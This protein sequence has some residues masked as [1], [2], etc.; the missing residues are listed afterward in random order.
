MYQNKKQ[1]EIFVGY[2]TLWEKPE[3]KTV[4]YMDFPGGPVVKIPYLHC[5]E[6]GFDPWLGN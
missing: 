6:H 4:E 1:L 5:R 2:P 3:S